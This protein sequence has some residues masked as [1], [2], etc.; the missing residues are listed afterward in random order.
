M[1]EKAIEKAACKWA[2]EHGWYHRKMKHPG[3]RGALDRI[4]HKLAKTVYIEFK[5]PGGRL[6]IH[7]LN[8]IKELETHFIQYAVVESVKSAK[9][10]LTLCDPETYGVTT[11]PE[12]GD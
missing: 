3:T 2:E 11:P 8:E 5:Q 9:D 12:E 7:Q 4:F 1:L 10:F 6:S